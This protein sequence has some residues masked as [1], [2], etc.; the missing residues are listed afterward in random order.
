MGL[1]I[2]PSHPRKLRATGAACA[3]SIRR[4]EFLAT[5]LMQAVARMYIQ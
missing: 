2:R 1:Q 3:T 4:A 5:L